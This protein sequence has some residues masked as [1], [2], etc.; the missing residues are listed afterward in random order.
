MIKKT[1]LSILTAASMFGC[2]NAI[3]SPEEFKLVWQ[4]DF[5]G[6]SINESTWS[7]IP[8][9]SSDW[10]RYMSDYDSL[11]AV[12]DGNLILRGIVNHSQK[13]DTARYL[14]GG[15][16]TKSKRNFELGRIEIRA[17][18]GSATGYWPAFWMLPET[19][20]WPQGGE[21]DIME[22]L[23]YD[24]VV[25]QTV[26]SNYTF[27]LKQKTPPPGTVPA[28]NRDDYNVF[29]LEKYKDSLCFFVNGIKTM[30]YPRVDSL[31]AKGQFP[32]CDEPYYLLLDSQLTGS[33]VGAADS[34][35]LPV[36]M[37]IDWVKF[38]ELK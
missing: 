33:W 12:R 32:F 19:A 27:V 5:D 14:T 30:T 7:K 1:L 26:H 13:S 37:A 38:Y 20:E 35:T 18:L 17:K 3:K 15:V 2:G 21:I 8:R 9:G 29:G 25:Y 31:V 36:E 11:Y 34:K 22:H 23:N 4:E 10:N 6:T 28:F 16:F 24:S